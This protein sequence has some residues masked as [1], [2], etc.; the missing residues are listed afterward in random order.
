MLLQGIEDGEFSGD[1]S[2]H[3][4]QHSEGT[5]FHAGKN[6]GVPDHW[7]LLN[8]Q[9]TLNVFHNKK[10]LRNIWES[11]TI[12]EIHFNAGVTTT[13]LVNNLDGYGTVWYH[14]SGI[15]NILPLSRVW[16]MSVTSH[17]TVSKEIDSSCPSL[18]TRLPMA[19]L[20]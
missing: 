8:N 20:W 18:R 1:S 10:L 6:G 16:K 13:T 12:M 5:V 4:L 14:P 17:M 11:G 7:I 15:A 19:S 3:F 2:F 9:S